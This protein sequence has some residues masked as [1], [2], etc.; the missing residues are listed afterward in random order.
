MRHAED[1]AYASIA[2]IAPRIE[3]GD[4]SPVELTQACLDRIAALDPSINAFITVTAE[5]A[6]EQAR[7][8]EADIQAGHYRGPLHGIPVAQKDLM[9]T[10]G[11]RTT[12]G[13]KVL[14]DHVPDH[15]AAVVTRLET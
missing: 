2:E 5:T 14:A 3:R 4:V 10:R 6:L 7:Q 12:G 11:V 8:A 9:F 1:L 15:D 13:S